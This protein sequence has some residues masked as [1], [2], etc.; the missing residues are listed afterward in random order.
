MLDPLYDDLPDDEELMTRD[1]EPNVLGINFDL[2]RQWLVP[3]LRPPAF[4]VLATS[5][6][7][8]T[9]RRPPVLQRLRPGPWCNS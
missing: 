1:L 5:A 9:D 4:P 6:W 8:S 3:R 2:S 7:L